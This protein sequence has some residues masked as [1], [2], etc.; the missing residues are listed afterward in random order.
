MVAVREH[1]PLERRSVVVVV[2][3][4][5]VSSMVVVDVNN[6]KNGKEASEVTEGKSCRMR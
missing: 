5:V 2:V 1:R 6:L 3:V 4:V